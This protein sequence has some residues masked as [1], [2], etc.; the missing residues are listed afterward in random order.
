MHCLGLMA[1]CLIANGRMP[2]TTGIALEPGDPNRA[3]AAVTFGLAVTQNAGKS[4]HWVCEEALGGQSSND[5]KVAMTGAGDILVVNSHGLFVSRD[6]GCSFQVVNKFVDGLADSVDATLEVTSVLVHPGTANT[7]LVTANS[8]AEQHGLVL[9]TDD[10]G[11][12]FVTQL[13]APSGEYFSGVAVAPS[14][15]NRIVAVGSNNASQDSCLLSLSRDRGASWTR[16]VVG[17]APSAS[18]TATVAISPVDENL[19]LL[20]V[21]DVSTNHTQIL[22][23]HD[24]GLSFVTVGSVDGPLRGLAFASDGVQV[25]VGIPDRINRSDDAGASFAA[26]ARPTA[27]ACVDLVGMTAYGCGNKRFDGFSLAKTTDGGGTWQ[28]VFD[29]TTLQGPYQCPAGSS[30]RDT[31]LAAWPQ[32]AKIIGAPV[33][34]VQEVSDPPAGGRDPNAPA[35]APVKSGCHCGA[36]SGVDLMAL[37]AVVAVVAL[38]GVLR[39]RSGR[40]SRANV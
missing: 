21:L 40:A 28:T 12:S 8:S 26:L 17:G 35:A 27:N 13:S 6:A 20:G 37:L 34:P 22:R 11:R 36:T 14:N 15:P 9:R 3:V 1:A 30:V 38:S 7:W 25:W 29:L 24:G 32:E 4:W 19:V 18:S 39:R 23:S 5:A 16:S 2:N 31:C 33:D 10:G